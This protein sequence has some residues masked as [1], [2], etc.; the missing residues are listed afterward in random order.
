[1][2]TG[3]VLGQHF[4]AVLVG[5]VESRPVRP[6]VVRRRGTGDVWPQVGPIQQRSQSLFQVVARP[7]IF[8]L[9]LDVRDECAAPR[10]IV[11]I[12]A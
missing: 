8:H 11:S 12:D 6:A 2:A 5:L 4:G 9:V 10:S 7:R 3:V 1:M